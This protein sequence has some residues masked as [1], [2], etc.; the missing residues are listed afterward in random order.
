MGHGQRQVRAER[1]EAVSTTQLVA[2]AVTGAVVGVLAGAF[3]KGGSAIATP[4]LAAIG[5]PAYVA[6]AAPLPATIPV[7][8][9][10]AS[11]YWGGGY[12][13]RRVLVH[14]VAWGV[15]ATVAGALLTGYVAG[16]VLVVATD[17]LILALGCRVVWSGWGGHRVDGGGDAHDGPGQ[18][19]TSA[20][21][22]A[23]VALAI[24]FSSGLL[25]NSG[26]ALLA[27]LYL[28]ILHMPIKRAFATSL[29]A[30]TVLAVPATVIHTTLGHI[31]WTVVAVFAAASIPFSGL[32]SRLAV[33][34]ESLRLQRVY[35]VV[36]T[37]LGLGFTLAR[38][39]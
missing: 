3:G 6:I 16:G 8:M 14:T 12:I 11:A 1:G 32:G 21:V 4:V 27:P 5:L 18:G 28:T 39:I 15:P 31:D 37:L 22:L 13:D 7:T 20:V 36:L 35:G 19:D 25:A 10:A 29:T 26:G 2:V 34:T 23:V 30:A 9:V 17:V 33:H 24:G 38:I